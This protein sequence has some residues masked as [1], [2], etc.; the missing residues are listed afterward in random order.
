MVD[1]LWCDGPGSG[2]VAIQRGRVLLFTRPGV[3]QRLPSLLSWEEWGAGVPPLLC[4]GTGD[5]VTIPPLHAPE[6]I[7]PYDVPPLPGPLPG[8]FLAHR[9]AAGPPRVAGPTP[10]PSSAGAPHP[11]A[12][13]PHPAPAGPELS[14]AE[15]GAYPDGAYGAAGAH[16]ARE[17]RAALPTR[18]AGAGVGP[19]GPP[20]PQGAAAPEGMAA[21]EGTAG[22][23][24]T[25]GAGATGGVSRWLVAP[26]VRHPWLPG[27]DVLLWACVRA[28]RGQTRSASADTAVTRASSVRRG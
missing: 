8:P 25:H 1:R 3:A 13:L 26:D 28:A 9:P 4:H 2:P 19:P 21:R 7:D 15:G 16:G 27:P 12:P 11:G 6:P 17:G 10:P 22:V 5:A 23:G 20:A 14:H 24:A 18:V